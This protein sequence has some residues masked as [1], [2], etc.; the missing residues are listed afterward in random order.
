MLESVSKSIHDTEFFFF[1]LLPFIVLCKEQ[2]KNH[3]LCHSDPN[4]NHSLRLVYKYSE[5]LW[6]VPRLKTFEKKK[7][8]KNLN[9]VLLTPVSLLSTAPE[10]E[11]LRLETQA[12]A[13]LRTHYLHFRQNGVSRQWGS[14]GCN[15]IGIRTTVKQFSTSYVTLY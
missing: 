14:L 12:K 4:I 7:R 13:I 5:A 3:H 2:Y 6:K 11:Y 8:K 1:F 15:V 10:K 9:Y